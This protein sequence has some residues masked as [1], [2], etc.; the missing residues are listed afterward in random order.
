M[1]ISGDSVIQLAVSAY[2]AAVPSDLCVSRFW[3]IFGK[4]KNP[5]SQRP[6]RTT[7][8]STENPARA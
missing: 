3:S 6:V 4:R 1:S 2:S 7:A 8:E 5:K